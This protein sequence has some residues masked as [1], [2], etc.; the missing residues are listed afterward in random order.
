LGNCNCIRIFRTDDYRIQLEN[1]RLNN[2]QLQSEIDRL[3]REY[4]SEF[5]EKEKRYQNRERVSF[6]VVIQKTHHCLE[7]GAIFER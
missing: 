1:E 3:R 4:A 5:H 6:L 2:E 7:L